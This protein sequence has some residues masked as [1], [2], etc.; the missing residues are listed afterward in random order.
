MVRT[1]DRQKVDSHTQ[2]CE[3]CAEVIFVKIEFI[4]KNPNIFNEVFQE[5]EATQSQ[6]FKEDDLNYDE[7]FTKFSCLN[8]VNNFLYSNLFSPEN[9]LRIFCLR[10]WIVLNQNSNIHI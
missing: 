6:L 3:D 4:F 2:D 10:L 7:E 9:N 1:N 8:D 5:D